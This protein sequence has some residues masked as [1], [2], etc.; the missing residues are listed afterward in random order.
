M[1]FKLSLF[2]EK[3]DALKKAQALADKRRRKEQQQRKAAA[4]EV[5]R[6]QRQ[7]EEEERRKKALEEKA[8][9]ARQEAE[10]RLKA[11]QEAEPPVICDLFEG[12]DLVE[13]DIGGR[14]VP[15]FE[16]ILDKVSSA[17][18]AT[19]DLKDARARMRPLEMH[20]SDVCAVQTKQAQMTPVMDKNSRGGL[21][22]S[23]PHQERNPSQE[24]TEIR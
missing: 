17:E 16:D 20:P 2:Q 3:Q 5:K 11:K 18:I 23:T 19:F 14:P 1:K 22:V 15:Y 6:K 8:K 4:E 21:A 7:Q 24:T 13:I 10:A 9:K 12:Q